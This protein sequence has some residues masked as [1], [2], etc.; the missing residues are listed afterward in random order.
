MTS[1]A[2][3]NA[4]TYELEI[5]NHRAAVDENVAATSGVRP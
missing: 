2:R 4:G 5:V 1:I 3:L